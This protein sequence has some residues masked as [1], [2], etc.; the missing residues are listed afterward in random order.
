M[1]I[2]YKLA[3]FD[4]DGTLADSFPWFLSVFDEVA[5]RFEFKRIQ[6]HEIARVRGLGSRR[7]LT[8]FGVSRWKLPRIAAHMRRLAARD[9]RSIRL[10]PGADRLLKRLADRGITIAI[11]SSNSEENIR[12]VLGPR[13][14]A[15][16]TYYGCGASLFGKRSK[17]RRV[18]RASRVDRGEVIC[19]GDEIR[20]AEAAHAEKIA[21]GAVAWGYASL[22][23]LEA[24]KPEHVFEAIEDIAA[25]LAPPEIP[26][27]QSGL[28]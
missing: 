19:I 4:F 20:D 22:E 16:V 26:E 3:I 8:H 9:A 12:L 24:Q 18:I 21:F 2:N 17:I 15:L 10:F 13:N 23:T 11:V 27:R 7:I 14:A 6:R 1:F 28:G 5:D 25:A